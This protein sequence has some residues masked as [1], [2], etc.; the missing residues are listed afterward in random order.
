MKGPNVSNLHP[1]FAGILAAHGLPQ[2]EPPVPVKRSDYVSALIRMGWTIDS[3]D[4]Y[5]ASAA[6]QAELARLRKMRREVDDVGF[7]WFDLAHPSF[8]DDGVL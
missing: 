1:V 4:G 3:V 5:L 7:L 8:R 6:G 2:D